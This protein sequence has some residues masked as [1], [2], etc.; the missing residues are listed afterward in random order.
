MK[1]EGGF[2]TSV[3]RAK[4]VG[5]DG[6]VITTRLMVKDVMSCYV[7]KILYVKKPHSTKPN[8]LLKSSTLLLYVKKPHSLRLH[9]MFEFWN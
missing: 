1:K 5:K 3:G 8:R 2:P 7:L 9:M 4:R 6:E